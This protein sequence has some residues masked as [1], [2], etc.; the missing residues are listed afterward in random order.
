MWKLINMFFCVLLVISCVGNINRNDETTKNNELMSA[1]KID[2]KSDNFNK[3]DYLERYFYEYQYYTISYQ[4]N[5]DNDIWKE[6]IIT[7]INNHNNSAVIHEK[8]KYFSILYSFYNNIEYSADFLISRERG[9]FN[10]N[11]NQIFR[12]IRNAL[13][14]RQIRNNDI[15]DDVKYLGDNLLTPFYRLKY[16]DTLTILN[17]KWESF[18]TPQAN[19]ENKYILIVEGN[20]IIIIFNGEAILCSNFRL[21]DEKIYVSNIRTWQNRHLSTDLNFDYILSDNTLRIIDLATFRKI[22]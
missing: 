18:W 14:S 1:W 13:T 22:E 20:L 3:L 10:E 16:N 2:W 21:T 8:H 12:Q 5:E 17:G 11:Y 6:E 15:D 9:I 7:K 4:I 19:Y